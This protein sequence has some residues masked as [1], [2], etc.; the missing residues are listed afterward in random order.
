[1]RPRGDVAELELL[2]ALDSEHSGPPAGESSPERRRTVAVGVTSAGKP[3]EPGQEALGG[4]RRGRLREDVL[5]AALRVDL[6][7]ALRAGGQVRQ[8]ALTR[9]MTELSVHQGGE[10]VSEMLFRELPR[11]GFGS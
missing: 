11:G 10:S 1:V 3:L 4:R 6:R 9:V 2:A 5:Q 7:P 8:D